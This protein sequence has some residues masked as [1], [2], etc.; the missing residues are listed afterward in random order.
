MERYKYKIAWCN[1]CNQGWINILKDR[2]TEEIF[3]SC[4][5]CESEWDT[6][7]SY[8][9]NDVGRFYTHGLANNP[10]CDEVLE[11]GWN[12]YIQ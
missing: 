10:E 7:E 9:N 3:V 5:E 11:L 1:I 4:D 12:K 8:L 6:P 2:E